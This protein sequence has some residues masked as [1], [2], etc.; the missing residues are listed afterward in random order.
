MKNMEC[1]KCCYEWEG[2]IGD[3]CPKCG[4]TLDDTVDKKEKK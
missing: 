3:S 2:N 4:A 1:L